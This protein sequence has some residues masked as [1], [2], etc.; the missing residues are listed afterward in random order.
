MGHTTQKR[1][2][3]PVPRVPSPK[4]AAEEALAYLEAHADAERAASLQRFFKEPVQS[5]GVEYGPFKGWKSGFL[6]RLAAGWSLGE[7]VELCT[8]LLEDDHMESRGLGY[9]VVGAFVDEAGPELAEKVNEWLAG[10]CGNWGLVDNLAPSVLTPLLRKHPELA[11]VVKGWAS[12]PNMWV[13]RG[14]AVAFVGLAGEAPFRDLPYEIATTLQG[15]REDLIQKAVGW[16]LR[17]AGKADRER[18]ETYLLDQGPRVPRTTLRYAI[19]KLPKED[20]KRIMAATR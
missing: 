20:R 2:V 12:S 9:Q 8:L 7:A 18:L 6:G 10:F 15:D 5:F 16:L 19:E 11:G 14:A 1:R 3:G 13:R 17:E 4:E